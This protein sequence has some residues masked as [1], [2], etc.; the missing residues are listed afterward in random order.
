M[1][2]LLPYSILVSLENLMDTNLWYK[3]SRRIGKELLEM[4]I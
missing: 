3:H 2:K 4:G 1:E